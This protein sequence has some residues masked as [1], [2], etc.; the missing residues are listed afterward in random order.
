MERNIKVIRKM[1]WLGSMV[2]VRGRKGAEP[3]LGF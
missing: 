2:K 3:Y 1:G